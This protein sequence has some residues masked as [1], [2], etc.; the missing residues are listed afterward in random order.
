M[1]GTLLHTDANCEMFRK[2]AISGKNIRIP[3]SVLLDFLLSR[4]IYS[5]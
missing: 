1:N 2:N 5:V 3:N 4:D